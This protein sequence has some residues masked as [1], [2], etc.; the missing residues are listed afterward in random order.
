MKFAPGV[1][2]ALAA[3][4]IAVPTAIA[5]EPLVDPSPPVCV[6]EGG[7]NCADSTSATDGSDSSDSQDAST[8]DQPSEPAPDSGSNPDPSD[9]AGS[10]DESTAPTDP[11]GTGSGEESG[12]TDQT[13]QC[14]MFI[15]DADGNAL[16]CPIPFEPPVV[17]ALAK[18]ASEEAAAA[19]DC[20][21]PVID[22]QKPE[23]CPGQEA[24]DLQVP[25]PVLVDDPLPIDLPK[26]C[27]LA[28][29][30][31]QADAD[32]AGCNGPVIGPRPVDCAPAP[33]Q[34]ETE[35]PLYKPEPPT[36][37]PND[38]GTPIYFGGCFKTDDGH[39]ACAEATSG[40]T[41]GG[42]GHGGPKVTDRG[43]KAPKP[44][45]PNT[46][47]KGRKHGSPK[48][49]AKHK[50]AANGKAKG[51]GKAKAKAKGNGKANGKANGKTKAKGKTNGKSK[52]NAKRNG[53]AK[54]AAPK[55]AR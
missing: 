18:F 2:A 10:T 19:A 8:V 7:S 38:P 29:F 17:C 35:C 36:V 16:P 33:D 27:L 39:V 43:G 23:Q 49:K 3:L 21:G 37:D 28:R 48:G 9:P 30:A 52:S 6:T 53:K 1:T 54:R 25:C 22:P 31:S 42:D 15:P 41:S 24:S 45:K 11:A 26:I 13:P 47:S 50:K 51:N 34:A 32:A 20:G 44:G 55:S 5:D 46:K 40:G 4:L 14:K 12:S